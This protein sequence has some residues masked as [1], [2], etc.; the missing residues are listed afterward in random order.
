M[1]VDVC[2]Y[3]CKCSSYGCV[4]IAAVRGHV[5]YYVGDQCSRHFGLKRVCAFEAHLGGLLATSRQS[6]L[7][8][9]VVWR[10]CAC[11]VFRFI[12]IFFIYLIF[13]YLLKRE[14]TVF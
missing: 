11:L 4:Y 6:W 10:S 9:N 1:F 7:K 14:P 5:L 2:M 12:F 3:I 13:Y 8:S